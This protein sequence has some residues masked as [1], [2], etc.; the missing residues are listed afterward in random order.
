MLKG[1]TV[2][3]NSPFLVSAAAG[4]WGTSGSNGGFAVLTFDGENLTG[5]LMAD[6]ISSIS[7]TLVFSGAYATTGTPT[8]TIGGIAATV[9]YSGLIGAGLYQINVTVPSSLV[10]GAY[11]VIVTQS[12]VSYPSTAVMKV[13]G[14]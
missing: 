5:S 2:T 11:P 13:A 14:S 10:T 12:G 4:N 9:L 3:S 1:V 7:A 6:S 8:V